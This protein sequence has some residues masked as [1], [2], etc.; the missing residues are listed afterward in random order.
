MKLFF[1]FLG[2]VLVLCLAK[3]VLAAI[4]NAVIGLF[5]GIGHGFKWVIDLWAEAKKEVYQKE[6]AKLDENFTLDLQFTFMKWQMWHGHSVKSL[7]NI[8]SSHKT[9]DPE[10]Q[11]AAKRFKIIRYNTNKAYAELLADH[12][13]A[14]RALAKRHGQVYDD[15]VS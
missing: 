10:W 5:R 2:V 4:G 13:Y 7:W 9:P 8:L 15:R 1:A 11:A 14:R 3:T 12:E 6:L